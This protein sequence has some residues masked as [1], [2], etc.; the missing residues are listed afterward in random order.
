MKD[1]KN[2]IINEKE[3]ESELRDQQFQERQKLLLLKD[4]VDKH[5]EDIKSISTLM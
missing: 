5:K 4:Q 3:K 1:I 2:Q